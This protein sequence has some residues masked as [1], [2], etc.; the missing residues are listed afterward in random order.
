[1][2]FETGTQ[3]LTNVLMK[4]INIK[5]IFL[6][7]DLSHPGMTEFFR[8]APSIFNIINALFPITYK[9]FIFLHTPILNSHIMVEFTGHSRI[10]GPHYENCFILSLQRIYC[11]LLCYLNEIVVKH[12][13]YLPTELKVQ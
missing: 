6:P 13:L 7:A 12:W 2:A 4:I 10:M 5:R 3:S 9:M 11:G 8:L 1:M